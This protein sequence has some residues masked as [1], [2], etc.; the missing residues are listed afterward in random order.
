M[1]KKNKVI[2]GDYEKKEIYFQSTWS[3]KKVFIQAGF[4]KKI[5]I[6]KATVDSYEVMDET[7]KNS[8]LSAVGRAAVGSFFLGAP[9]LAAALGAKKKRNHVVAIQ[10]KDGKRSLIEVDDKIYRAIMTSV[11]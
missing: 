11:F 6:D 8:T 2:A 1:A 4:F 7:S 10:F 9:G 3:G 5:I